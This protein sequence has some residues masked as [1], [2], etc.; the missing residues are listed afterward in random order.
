MRT[1]IKELEK[2]RKGMDAP[3]GVTYN[4]KSFDDQTFPYLTVGNIFRW[5]QYFDRMETLTADQPKHLLHVQ[6]VRRKLDFATLWKWLDLAK[7]HPEYFKD[8]RTI[9]QRIRDTNAAVGAK[10]FVRPVGASIVDDFILKIKAGGKQPPL[11]P[12][13]GDIDPKRVRQLVPTGSRA[14]S[15]YVEDPEAAFGYA[16]PVHLPDMPFNF[17]FYQKDRAT[18]DESALPK[19]PEGSKAT[20]QRALNRKFTLQRGLSA[21]EITPGKYRIYELGEIEIS[22][23]CMFWFSAQSWA[24]HVELGRRLYEPGAENRWEAYASMKFDGPTYGG[25]AEKDQVLVDRIILLRKGKD[26]FAR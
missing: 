9:A 10:R 13:L 6:T 18:R 7:K 12:Q 22:P 21:D 4:S 17:G 14:T 8:Y 1:Y 23:D 25:T 26:Q 3:P 15:P 24:T 5:Q 16:S 20:W 11:P 19:L 2:G